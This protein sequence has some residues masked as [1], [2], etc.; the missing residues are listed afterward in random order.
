MV[1]TIRNENNI[2]AKKEA[3]LLLNALGR[4]IKNIDRKLM[5]IGL[6]KTAKIQYISENELNQD[7][8]PQKKIIKKSIDELKEIARLRRIK[9]RDKLTKEGLIINLLQSESTDAERNYMK[10]FNNNTND[11]N[12]TYDGKI[13]GNNI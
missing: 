8:K 13:R 4:K 6:G 3:L 10:H 1:K 12:D 2:I 5:K 9:N 7:E 11:D